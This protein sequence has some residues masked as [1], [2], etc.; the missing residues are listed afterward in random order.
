MKSFKEQVEK[1]S[2]EDKLEGYAWRTDTFDKDSTRFIGLWCFGIIS[3]GIVTVDWDEYL[4]GDVYAYP[5]G[6][7]YCVARAGNLTD[8]FQ[9][10]YNC[11]LFGG[12]EEERV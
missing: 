3:Y 11:I 12:P 2:E 4:A 10:V 6:R 9:Y 5:G 8:A 1:Q 7:G